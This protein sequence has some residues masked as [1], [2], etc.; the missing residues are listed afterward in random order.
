MVSL[1]LDGVVAFIP[2]NLVPKKKVFT[3]GEPVECVVDSV[4]DAARTVTLKT[5][6]ATARK[7]AITSRKLAFRGLSAGMLVDAIVDREVQNGLLVT[8][9]ASFHGMI[10]NNHFAE[11][12]SGD[13]WRGV[14][15]EG[16]TLKARII[17]VDYV[18]KSVRLSLK[19]HVVNYYA[20]KVTFPCCN[21]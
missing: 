6:P 1:G 18:G 12:Q 13:D 3:I 16:D 2:H 7:A 5:A 19:P 8:F 11:L 15:K 20:I 10:D 21:R 9:L 14:Y 4:N 17:F